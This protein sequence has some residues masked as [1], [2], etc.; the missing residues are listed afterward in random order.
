MLKIVYS[1]NS[2][3]Y[4]FLVDPNSEF[5]PGM[6]GELKA[7]GQ[8]TV[9]GV[10]GGRNPIGILDDNKTRSFS[11]AVIDEVLIVPVSDPVYNSNNRL[12]TPVEII[13]ELANPLISAS[14]FVSSPIA[15]S[16]NANNGTFHILA[17]TELN[18]SQT[19]SGELDAIR[20]VVRYSHQVANVIGEDSTQGSG[21]VT[22][23]IQPGT[24]FQTDIYDTSQQYPLN[25]LLYCGLDG[26]LTSAQIDEEF[27][28]VAIITGSPTAIY[29]SIEAKWLI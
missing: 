3:P 14:S 19:N 12:V 16:L 18:L 5:E 26:R 15:G 11:R 27:P 20:T 2:L 17:G 29:G 22:V 28:A 21:Q 6:I 10:S 23:W 7:W 13:V 4:S 24:I 8:Q 9:C 1:G 25:A